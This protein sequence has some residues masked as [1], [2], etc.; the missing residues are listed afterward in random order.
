MKINERTAKAT[1]AIVAL[2][3]RAKRLRWAI[4]TLERVY[5][6]RNRTERDMADVT[7]A[8]AYLDTEGVLVHPSHRYMCW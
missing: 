5:A 1:E 8:I 4:T 2:E 3:T 6:K 7:Q